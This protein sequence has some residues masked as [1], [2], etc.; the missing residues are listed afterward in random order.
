[1][2]I[3]TVKQAARLRIYAMER[4]REDDDRGMGGALQHR[5]FWLQP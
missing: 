3:C 4:E 2:A 5:V 1:M